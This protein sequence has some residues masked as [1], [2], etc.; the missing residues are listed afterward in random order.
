M[1]LWRWRS[2]ANG[3]RLGLVCCMLVTSGCVGVLDPIVGPSIDT[4]DNPTIDQAIG[5]ANNLKSQ[6]KA[7]VQN[8]A[9]LVTWVGA[10]LIPLAAATTGAGVLLAHSA[11]TVGILGL[12]GASAFGAASYL[13]N[14]PA[15]LAYLA[16]HEA[17]NCAVR[18]VAPLRIANTPGF[19]SALDSI[20]NDI[21]NAR[22]ALAGAQ[23]AAAR[24]RASPG[25]AVAKSQLQTAERSIAEAEKT[26]AAGV[27]LQ[28][29]LAAMP[30]RLVTTVD[31][32][33]N[34]VDRAVVRNLPDFAALS[35]TIGGLA[36]F[37]K[38][39]TTITPISKGAPE[40]PPSGAVPHGLELEDGLG[41]AMQELQR[42]MA[43]LATSQ[44]VIAGVVNAVDADKPAKDLDAC[45]VSP[46]DLAGDLAFDPPGPYI[47][48]AGAAAKKG[49]ILRGGRTPYAANVDAPGNSVVIRQ[50]VPFEPEFVIETTAAAKGTYV[51]F[52]RDGSGRKQMTELNVGSGGGAGGAGGGNAGGGTRGPTPPGG[53]QGRTVPDCAG[54]RDTDDARLCTTVPDFKRIQKALCLPALQQTGKWGFQSGSALREFKRTMQ[55]KTAPDD[56]LTV[57]DRRDLL[58]QTD[59]NIRARCGDPQLLD[60]LEEAAHQLR[61]KQI[62]L[63]Q[64]K[65]TV[66][67]AQPNGRKG[68]IEISL[69]ATVAPGPGVDIPG[70]AKAAFDQ[71]LTRDGTP[72][73]PE[74]DVAKL[75]I[76]DQN[77]AEATSVGA[78]AMCH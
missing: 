71:R 23:L 54:L 12:T 39:F 24:S 30:L 75:K 61:G 59:D 7:A 40:A 32:I 49:F 22:A 38:Q 67:G 25:L 77:R 50:P 48:A 35:A 20:G 3:S 11:T 55:G 41:A 33:Q 42:R 14:Q 17:L 28:A 47:L 46:D 16:G 8:Q 56:V 74:I 18:V 21:A 73:I 10:G 44:S 13:R 63:L 15:Q 29:E 26:Q 5:Y 1:T 64:S 37:Y 45:G 2:W 76:I 43:E 52:A 66:L 36:G 69:C 58:A 78:I 70:L 57:A 34:E 68:T 53:A 65:F 62:T 9:R 31:R 4:L 19:A 6:Y 51:I 72:L 27:K 60:N